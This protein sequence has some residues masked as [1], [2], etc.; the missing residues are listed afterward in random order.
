M[1]CSKHNL[2]AF[3][4]ASLLASGSVLAGTSDLATG[5]IVAVDTGSH[6]L[7]LKFDDGTTSTTPVEG[8]AV[9]EFGHL[10]PGE[11]VSVRF[12]ETPKGAHEAI[13]ALTIYKTVKVF[14]G[15]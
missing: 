8:T 11:M 6:T 14:E 12:R 9:E 2:C 3:V 4:A 1:H 15:G 10:K 13:T 7:T 5:T